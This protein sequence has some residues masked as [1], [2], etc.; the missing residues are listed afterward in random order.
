MNQQ[1]Q[2]A[3]EIC[4]GPQCSDCGGR[5]LAGEIRAAGLTILE[6]DCRNLCPHAPVV[7]IDNHMI[8]KATLAKVLQRVADIRSGRWRSPYD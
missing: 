1:Q 3:I 8:G 6:G 2:P 4:F 5:E 7:I